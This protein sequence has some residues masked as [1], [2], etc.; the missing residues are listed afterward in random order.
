M[1]FSIRTSCVLYTDF[2]VN[3]TGTLSRSGSLVKNEQ[4]HTFT[5]FPDT[6]GSDEDD[7]ENVRLYIFVIH[8]YF[9]VMMSVPCMD[10]V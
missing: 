10:N 5:H 9:E 6:P 3:T 7:T 4:L 2:G 1:T 8:S